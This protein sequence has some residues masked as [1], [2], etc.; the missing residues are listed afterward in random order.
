[1]HPWIV[2]QHVAWEGPGLIARIGEARGLRFEVRRM[3]R[4]EGLP[5]IDQA[6]GLVVMGGPMGAGDTVEHP[7][8]A[9]ERKLLAEAMRRGVPVLGVCLG[10]QLLAAALGARVYT[11]PSPEVGF[12]EVLL[13]EEGLRDPVLGP[14]GAA[15]PAF[16]W[17]G[18]TFDLPAAATHLA[19]SEKYPH[20]AFRAGSRAY[21]FQFHVEVDEELARGWAPRLP[22]GLKI[23]EA[24]RR[25]VE[26]G[27][28][29][30][31]G[32]FF[33]LARG[34]RPAGS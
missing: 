10:S 6:G 29:A 18:D 20:Q 34:S 9:D 2:I 22:G 30:I 26:E 1:M 31:L 16:H 21:A 24:R 13:T 23:D 33:D 19:R 25:E 7:H 3:D 4:G 17:H 5:G 32:R 14:A 28:K 8:L 12:G 11:G 27:G 15:V